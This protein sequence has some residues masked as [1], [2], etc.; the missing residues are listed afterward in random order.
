MP[1]PYSIDDRVWNAFADWCCERGHDV[2]DS[3]LLLAFVAGAIYGVKM[4][5]TEVKN[6][7]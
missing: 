2:N 4:T 5:A 1:N 3:N 7:G 6:N